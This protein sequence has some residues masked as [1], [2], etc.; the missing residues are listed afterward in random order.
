MLNSILISHS[1]FLINNPLLLPIAT[2]CRTESELALHGRVISSSSI[3][4]DSKSL[5]SRLGRRDVNL[6]RLLLDGDVEDLA[7]FLRE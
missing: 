7:V 4:G 6:R 3:C 1:A 5:K 2:P